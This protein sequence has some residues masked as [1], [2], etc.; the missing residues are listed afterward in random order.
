MIARPKIGLYRLIDL[1][2]V[3]AL[4]VSMHLGFTDGP[5]VPHNL[6]SVQESPVPLPKLQ[7]APDLKS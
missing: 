2:W 1:Y 5:F 4:K 3:R 6:I 7:M